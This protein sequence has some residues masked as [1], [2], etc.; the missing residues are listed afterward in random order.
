MKQFKNWYNDDEQ[1]RISFW[2]VVVFVVV[3]GG[4]IAYLVS[5]R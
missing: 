1:N 3:I 4:T 2:S 5:I